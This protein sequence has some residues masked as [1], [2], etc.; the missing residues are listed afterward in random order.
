MGEELSRMQRQLSPHAVR[1]RAHID[2][3]QPFITSPGAGHFA[4]SVGVAGSVE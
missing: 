4:E 3:T 2:L 1:E